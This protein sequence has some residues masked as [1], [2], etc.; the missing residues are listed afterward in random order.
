MSTVNPENIQI[1][2]SMWTFKVTYLLFQ[3]LFV[4]KTPLKRPVLHTF[5]VSSLPWHFRF[6]ALPE[7][8]PSRDTGSFAAFNVKLGN[9]I[10]SPKSWLIESTIKPVTTVFKSHFYIYTI[11]PEKQLKLLHQRSIWLVFSCNKYWINQ[12]F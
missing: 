5:V 1:N 4:D 6:S 10:I 11:S 12:Y 2:S 9:L 7:P 3:R 8:R